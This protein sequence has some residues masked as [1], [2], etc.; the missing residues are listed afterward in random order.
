MFA[1]VELLVVAVVVCYGLKHIQGQNIKLNASEVKYY[2]IVLTGHCRKFI[3]VPSDSAEKAE[4]F[5]WHCSG[6]FTYKGKTC[7]ITLSGSSFN[8][9]EFISPGIV[10]YLPEHYVKNLLI[11]SEKAV[12]YFCKV[13][14]GF[15]VT[16]IFF[17]TVHSI[18]STQPL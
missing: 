2:Q 10:Q 12:R 1:A 14:I 9:I 4:F 15:N 18:A 16:T 17:F 13:K 8:C 3:L 11:L 6:L 5:K 7:D